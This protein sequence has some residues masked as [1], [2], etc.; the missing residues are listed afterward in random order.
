[1]AKELIRLLEHKR[2][3]ATAPCRIDMG[4]TLDI[5]VFYRPLRHY[6]PC[7]FNVALDL[8]TKVSLFPYRPGKVRI[9][10]LGFEDAIFE[11][12]HAPFTHPLGLMFAIGRYFNADGVHIQIDSQSPPRSGLG[13]SSTAAVALVGALSQAI[14]GSKGEPEAGERLHKR[15]IALLAYAM[16][17]SV[18]GVP[19]GLQDH[20]AAA[21]GGVNAW[22]WQT[23]ITKPLFKKETVVKKAGHKRLEGRLLIAYAGIPHESRDINGIWVSRFLAGKDRSLWEGIIRDTRGFIGALKDDDVE[24][25]VFF[26]RKEVEKRLEMTPDVLDGVGKQLVE[27]AGDHGC[28]ARFTGAGGGGCIW[29]FGRSE[30]IAFLKNTWETILSDKKDAVILN[31]RIDSGG[32]KYR[33]D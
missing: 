10:S 7:T 15:Q 26:I 13:G 22:H 27:T 2:I 23:G 16:E 31:T 12:E 20:L 21:Y 3:E 19:C 25:A 32:M 11:L 6:N 28:G 8:K 9:S 30:K 14:A 18:A 33:I 5:G 29:A 1:M 17:E 24:E 4:G